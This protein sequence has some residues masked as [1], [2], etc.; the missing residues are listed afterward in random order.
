MQ[1]SGADTENYFSGGPNE[2]RYRR[3]IIT[4]ITIDRFRFFEGGPDPLYPPLA[5]ITKL[6]KQT[7]FQP[8]DHKNWQNRNQNIKAN[9]K[10]ITPIFVFQ[11]N[12]L[13]GIR[14]IFQFFKLLTYNL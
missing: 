12:L 8:N 14:D 1:K 3:S 13:I 6:Q 11:K 5:G 9:H 2:E 4:Q 7:T 10:V